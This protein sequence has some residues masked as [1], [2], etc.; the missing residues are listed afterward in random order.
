SKRQIENSHASG[1][2]FE[3][4]WWKKVLADPL[5]FFS[6]D[7]AKACKVSH[8]GLVTR[9]VLSLDKG[10]EVP[11][12]IKRPIARNWR[13]AL[14]QAL[15]PS[16]CLRGWNTGHSLIHRDIP[17][18]R[19]LVVLERRV[20]PIVRDSILITEALPGALDLDAH[21]KREFTARSQREWLQHKLE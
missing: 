9:A 2:V 10:G 15:P 4:K 8:S 11:V 7:A 17:A 14:R 13:R 3:R 1:L 19:P 18:A 6:G 20:G 12:I 16:R 21:L 5:R